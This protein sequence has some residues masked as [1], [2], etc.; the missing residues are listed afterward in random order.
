M[1][2]MLLTDSSAYFDLV[3][4][5]KLRYFTGGSHIIDACQ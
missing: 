3:K 1:L 2:T 5:P 4:K